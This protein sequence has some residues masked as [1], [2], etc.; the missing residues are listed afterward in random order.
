MAT[1][2]YPPPPRAVGRGAID[3]MSAA[4]HSF[5]TWRTMYAAAP[6][7]H[8][9]PGRD[10]SVPA[11][12]PKATVDHERPAA[13]LIERP[14]KT[15]IRF[16][17][18]RIF[19][20]PTDIFGKPPSKADARV[21]RV[22]CTRESAGRSV[23]TWISRCGGLRVADGVRGH[24]RL[25]LVAFSQRRPAAVTCLRCSSLFNSSNSIP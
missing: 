2:R 24:M 12:A 17:Q 25:R 10:H 20:V 11:D 14:A 4:P 19:P 15:T 3:I 1:G 16:V 9:A 22:K 7:P 8:G 13:E 6:P 21:E 18:V 23:S 5:L